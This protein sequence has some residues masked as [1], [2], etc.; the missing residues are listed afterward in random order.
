MPCSPARKF[1]PLHQRHAVQLLA[2][3]RHRD[4]ALEADLDVGR[5]FRR[6]L[7]RPRQLVDVL[8]RLRQ[9]SSSTPHSMLR[10]HRFS[11]VE[12]GL[13]FVTGMGMLCFAA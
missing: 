2:V 13:S 6:V 7:H 9:G 8:R 3:Q 4:A 12:Y 10:P 11:S 1:E 5:L